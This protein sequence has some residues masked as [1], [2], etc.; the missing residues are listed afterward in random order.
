MPAALAATEGGARLSTMRSIYRPLLGRPLTDGEQLV[1]VTDYSE[2][3]RAALAGAA[4]DAG[5]PEIFVPR[6]IA[7][8]AKVPIL[9][10]G[11][12]DYVTAGKVALEMAAEKATA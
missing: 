1:L 12:V 3:N 2:A 10:T 11:K 4:R 6:S 8:V 7:R 9:G 5:I